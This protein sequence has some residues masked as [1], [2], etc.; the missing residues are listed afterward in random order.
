[1]LELDRPFLPPLPLRGP[2]PFDGEQGGDAACGALNVLQGN[3]GEIATAQLEISKA[4]PS[5]KVGGIGCVIL[6]DVPFS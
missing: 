4:S 3:N 6:L 2:L 5:I 1:M